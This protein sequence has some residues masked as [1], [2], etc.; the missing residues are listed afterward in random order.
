MPKLAKILLVDDNPTYLTDVLPIC[1]YEVC[2]VTDGENA[3]KHLYSSKNFDIVL[4]EVT[5][6]NISGFEVLKRIRSESPCKNIPVILIS[7][8]DDE[9]KIIAGLNLGAD[10]Y[11]VKPYVLPILIARIEAV[12]RRAKRLQQDDLVE[13]VTN[14]QN[15][16][17]YFLTK[18]EKDVL[19]LVTKG[20]SNKSIAEKLVL[21][22]ITVKSHLNSIFKKLNVTNRTQAVLLAMQTNLV[23]D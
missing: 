4:L 20:E 15:N 2:Y 8:I 16:Q 5:L 17:K 12:L 14:G 21:S 13:I 3:L 18:R 9:Q 7:K 11:V 23:E 22:E 6:P 1:G 19:L 10:D